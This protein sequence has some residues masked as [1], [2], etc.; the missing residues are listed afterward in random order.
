VRGKQGRPIKR[1]LRI[2]A[3]PATY[4]PFGILLAAREECLV[5]HADFTDKPAP[6]L[7]TMLCVADV[8]AV[9]EQTRKP[10]IT[11]YKKS[12]CTNDL[13]LHIRFSFWAEYSIIGYHACKNTIIK[14]T[15]MTKLNNLSAKTGGA[16]KTD[17]LGFFKK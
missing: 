1:L 11:R 16:L 17:F 8:V 12:L 5:P 9:T 3:A 2:A 14:L 13:R 7:K 6:L 15:V 10:G 4:L